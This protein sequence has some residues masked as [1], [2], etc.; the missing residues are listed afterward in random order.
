[1]KK[2]SLLFSLLLIAALFPSAA[3][4][5]RYNSLKFTSVSGETYT[6]AS[7]NLEIFVEGENLAFNNT[8]LTLPLSSLVSM[9]FTDTYDSPSAIEDIVFDRDGAVKVYDLGGTPTGSFDSFSEA[10]ASLPKGIYVIKDSN[11]YSLKVTVEK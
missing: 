10:L 3:F 9:E 8:E 6:L 11:G 5:G 2:K 7:D 1:M 4:S